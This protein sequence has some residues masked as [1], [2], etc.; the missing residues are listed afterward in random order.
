MRTRGRGRWLADIACR[1]INDKED[2]IMNIFRLFSK[3]T[4]VGFLVIAALVVT[5]TNAPV[6]AANGRSLNSVLSATEAEMLTYMREEEKLARDVYMVMYEQWAAAIFSTIASSEQQ[7]MDTMKKKLDKYNLP[8]PALPT[9][10]LFTNTD[11]QGKYD[12]LVESGSA[13]YVAGLNVGA[14]IEEIDMVDIQHAID[15][16]THVD[17]VNAYQ[18]LLEGSKNHL[19]AYV[20]ALATQGVTYA[21]QYI[22]Q[23]LFDAIMG[24]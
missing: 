24:G 19:R 17:V 15:I 6:W 18:N 16:T 7:H 1:N 22:S 12:Q 11:L 2:F 23:E 13:S 5:L 14:T 8:D 10:G 21:P 4:V 9:N 3:I 20:G